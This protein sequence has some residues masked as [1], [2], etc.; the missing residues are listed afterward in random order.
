MERQQSITSMT[1]LFQQFQTHNKVKNLSE[2]TI[3]YYYWN[4]KSFIDYLSSESIVSIND[5]NSSVLDNYILSQKEKY[6][7]TTSINTHLR[8]VRAF[9]YWCM[10][11]DYLKPFKIHLL[12]QKE[13]PLK[14]YSDDDIQ[15]LIAK[16]NLKECSFVE[17]RGWI[18]VNWFIETGNRLRSVINIK[19]SDIDFTGYKVIIRETKNK[20]LLITPLTKTLLSILP[21]YIKTWGLKA[22]QYLFPDFKG[23]QMTENAA[24][25]AIAVYNRKHGVKVTSIHA[26]RHTFARNYIVT[27]GNTF[28]LQSLLG[29]KDLTMTRH[30]VHLFGEDLASDI[31]EHSIVERIKPTSNRFT[32][33]KRRV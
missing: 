28:K 23:N 3:D 6:K 10:D 14:L 7:N 24:K 2:K 26:F 30:Y 18:M 20:E 16:P 25:H 11:N 4:L 21:P 32:K 29:H 31:D 12:K 1:S 8:A 33:N 13:E 22:E 19:I 9:L 15:K 17:Y 5:V 27:G